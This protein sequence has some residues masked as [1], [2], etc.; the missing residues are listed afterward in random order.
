MFTTAGKADV[1]AAVVDVVVLV[2][3][4]F[5]DVR[6]EHVDGRREIEEV[7]AVVETLTVEV[8]RPEKWWWEGGPSG[9]EGEELVDGWAED[10][11]EKLA[12]GLG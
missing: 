1:L 10:I 12:G 7:G 2:V 4:V 5:D 6:G 3:V 11:R 9:D 8:D